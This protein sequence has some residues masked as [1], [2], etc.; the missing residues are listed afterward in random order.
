MTLNA[1]DT[2]LTISAPSEGFYKEKGSKFLA[3]AYPV[4]GEEDIK[5]YLDELRKQYYDARHFCYAYMLGKEQEVFR[6]NDDGE[7]NHSAGDPILGQ[8]RSA[9][10]TDILIVVV[11]YFGG[12]KLGVG[13]LITAYK[14][15]AAE[16]I[17]NAEILEKIVSKPIYLELEYP[18]MNEVM[19]IIKEYELEIISQEMKLSCKFALSVRERD[20]EIVLEKLK[21]LEA[22]GKLKFLGD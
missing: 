19:R 9:N 8:I 14:I 4:L 22:L 2:F 18:E 6:A 1:T 15:A 21:L 17:Q 13:G 7:P 5:E 11:R 3:F 10:L 12:T 20:F 16:A